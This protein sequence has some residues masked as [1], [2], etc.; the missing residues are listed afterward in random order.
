[1][2]VLIVE[3]EKLAAD[4]L[5]ELLH[6]YDSS[7]NVVAKLDSV[8]AT[9]DWLNEFSVDL[10]FLDIHLSDDIGF[11]IFELM[12]VKTPVIFITAYDEYALKAFSINSIDYLL[13]PIDFEKLSLALNKLENFKKEFTPDF[14]QLIE[15]FKTRD[16]DYQKRFM[17]HSGDKIISI[18]DTDVAYFYAQQ[19]F[20]VIITLTGQQYVIDYTLEGLEQKLNPR[21][22]F[23]IN[24]QYILCF[25]AI[26]TMYPY[27]KGRI[28]IDLQPDAKETVIVSVDKAA[29]F[30][31]WL[32]E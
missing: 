19:R 25:A 14:A 23:R 9:V 2:N 21:H 8:K 3:D 24:R 11:K 32:N 29:K 15:T 6:Q 17:V 4:E 20:V 26:K 28:K 1:M 12:H 10:I 5:E 27:T 18:Q 31:Q 30:K 7:I 22:F 13:K 16:F